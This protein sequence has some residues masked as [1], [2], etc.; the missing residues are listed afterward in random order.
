M[1][2]NTKEMSYDEMLKLPRL[3]HKKPMM[4][5]GWLATIVR[6]AIAPT[7]WKTKF[8]YTTERMELVGDQPCLIFMNKFQELKSM[9]ESEDVDGMRKMMR[10]STERRA[11]FDKK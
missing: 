11:L 10:H 6:I 5:Q 4:P 1:K 9:L 2:I 7:L 8:S 3:Q